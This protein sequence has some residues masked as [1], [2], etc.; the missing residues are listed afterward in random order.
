MNCFFVFYFG[1]AIIANSMLIVPFDF[2]THAKFFD[3]IYVHDRKDIYA[4]TKPKTR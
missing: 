3:G 2:A 4:I 1:F